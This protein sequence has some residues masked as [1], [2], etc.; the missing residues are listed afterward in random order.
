MVRIQLSSNYQVVELSY[1][2]WESVNREEV[3]AATELVNELGAAVD[4]KGP[5]R[6]GTAINPP[7]RP[8]RPARPAARRVPAYEPATAKQLA[9]LDSLGVPYEDGISKQEAW[10]LAQEYQGY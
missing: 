4:V 10:Q 2:S 5:A 6:Q 1:D 3:D 9:Y 8:A 7:Q